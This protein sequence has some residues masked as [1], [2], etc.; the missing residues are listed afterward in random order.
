MS[1][2]YV[3]DKNMVLSRRISLNCVYVLYSAAVIVTDFVTQMIY[4]NVTS[5]EGRQ[6]LI[7]FIILL[8]R[9]TIVS[10]ECFTDIIF[11]VALWPWGRLTL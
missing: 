9:S 3:F 1:S 10:L 6:L 5:Y 7:F 11:P 4:L 8:S 2:V